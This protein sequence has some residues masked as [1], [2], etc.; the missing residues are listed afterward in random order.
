MD[1]GEHASGRLV[2][3]LDGGFQDSLRDVVGLGARG[4]FGAN[5]KAV[6]GVAIGGIF[7]HRLLQLGQPS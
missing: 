7:L 3:D 6:V 4:W 5:E 1:V 2:G